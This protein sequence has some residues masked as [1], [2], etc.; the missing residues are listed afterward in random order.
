MF[1][2]NYMEEPATCIGL[3]PVVSSA[4]ELDGQQL[5]PKI[6][7]A[8][9]LHQQLILSLASLQGF[10]YLRHSLLLLIP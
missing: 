4:V 1:L 6:V 10:T 8:K 9:N 2:C 7:S 5:L 3:A